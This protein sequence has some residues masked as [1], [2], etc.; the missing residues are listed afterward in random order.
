MFCVVN[1][2]VFVAGSCGRK[3]VQTVW[4]FSEV[5][6]SSGLSGHHRSGLGVCLSNEFRDT[7]CEGRGEEISPLA[8]SQVIGGLE[9]RV[10]RMTC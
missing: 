6:Q 4:R 9:F 1:G 8:V 10:E 2:D 5:T 7:N 3:P